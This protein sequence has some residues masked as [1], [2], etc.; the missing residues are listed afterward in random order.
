MTGRFSVSF[1]GRRD[2]DDPWFRVGT[3]DITTTAFVAIAVA[4]SMFVWAA[5]SSALL[6]L[7]LLPDKVRGGQ[8]WRLITWPW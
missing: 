7:A 3:L 4:I 1:P 2:H 5:S 6:S 8:A